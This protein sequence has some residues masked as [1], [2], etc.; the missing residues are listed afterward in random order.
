MAETT[1]IQTLIF[2]KRRYTRE[3]AA[4]WLSEHGFH[5]RKIDET[6]DSLRFRQREP[7]E[8]QAGSFR[9]VPITGGIQAVIGRLS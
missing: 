7:S 3:Q 4:R 8:F 6:E 2:S 5:S 9:T 1:T